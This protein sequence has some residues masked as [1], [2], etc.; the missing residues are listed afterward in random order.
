MS[1]SSYQE[2]VSAV[3]REVYERMVEALAVGHWPDG[4]T[5]S[6]EQKKQTMEAVILWGQLHLPEN[7]RVGYIDKGSKA[8]S[9]CDEPQPL[10]WK[11]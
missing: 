3:P 9:N 8:G 7:E 10:T 5:L 11:E 2:M 6:P 4:S 1:Q